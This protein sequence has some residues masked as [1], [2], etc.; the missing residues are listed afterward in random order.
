MSQKE[1][2]PFIQIKLNE[3]ITLTT[4]NPQIYHL[5]HLITAKMETLKQPEGYNQI[6]SN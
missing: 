1:K 6:L 3:N 2:D 5:F 4:Q